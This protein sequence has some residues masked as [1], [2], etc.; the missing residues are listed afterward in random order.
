MFFFLA[1]CLSLVTIFPVPGPSQDAEAL[2]PVLSVPRLA[3]LYRFDRSGKTGEA[4]RGAPVF[5]RSGRYLV[6]RTEPVV[7]IDL[8]GYRLVRLAVSGPVS[9]GW[10]ADD[11][12]IS[13]SQGIERW[14]LPSETR[15]SSVAGKPYLSAAVSPSGER[16][17]TFGAFLEPDVVHDLLTSKCWPLNR[18]FGMTTRVLWLPSGDRFALVSRD[19]FCGNASGDGALAIVDREGRV[20]RSRALDE[21]HV[22]RSWAFSSDGRWLLTATPSGLELRN[23]ESLELRYRRE[24]SARGVAFLDD[25]R[26][27]VAEPRE[28]TL[29]HPATLTRVG[30]LL[31][32]EVDH[33]VLS[34]HRRHLVL[35]VAETERVYAIVE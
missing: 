23:G 30:H 1:M 12:L 13:T 7:A 15:L 35:S 31:E 29:W 11:L 28:L 20:L 21:A 4:S 10:G 26:A 27:L 34:P 32:L 24:V 9:S 5:T 17:V 8:Q 14:D 6:F 16:L 3:E 25:R 33:L 18:T 22:P 2:P 19:S